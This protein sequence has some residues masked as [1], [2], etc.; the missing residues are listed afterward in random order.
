MKA[1]CVG[2]PSRCSFPFPIVRRTASRLSPMMGTNSGKEDGDLIANWSKRT[3][4]L[5][6]PYQN[7]MT[8]DVQDYFQVEAFFGVIERKDWGSYACRVERNTDQ[9][10][11]MFQST[12]AK[13]TFFTLGWVAKRYPA[14]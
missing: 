4:S 10:L 11:S 12:G 8:V 7:M 14:L 9:I 1:S 2:W 6:G 5:T 3:V 13:A